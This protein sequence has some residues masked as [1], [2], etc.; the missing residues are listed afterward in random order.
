MTQPIVTVLVDV[1][2]VINAHWTTRADL[3]HWPVDSWQKVRVPVTWAGVA[4][5]VTCSTC[6]IDGLRRI[7]A[8]PATSMTWCTTWRGDAASSLGPAI[9]LGANWPVVDHDLPHELEWMGWWKAAR[10]YEC[11][12]THERVVWIDDAA[13]A[14][15]ASMYEADLGEYLRWLDDRVLIISPRTAQGL[16]AE[17]L[18]EIAQFLSR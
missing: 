14:W 12:L 15:A 8:L 1:D 6:V 4:V 7:E 9:G 13:A 11:S 16:A 10:A 17:H 5:D 18:D 2:G 3:D